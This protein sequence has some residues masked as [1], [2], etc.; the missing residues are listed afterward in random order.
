M[1]SWITQNTQLPGPIIHKR[2][3]NLMPGLPAK[4]IASSML[5]SFD[6]LKVFVALSAA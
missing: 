2:F 1:G 4:K 5:P 6:G 3:K